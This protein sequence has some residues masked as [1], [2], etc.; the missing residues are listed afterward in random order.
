[1]KNINTIKINLKGGVIAPDN[2]YNIL[3]AASKFRILYVRFGLRQQLLID[4]EIEELK[5]LTAELDMLGI[6]YEVNSEHHPNIVSSY[7]AED[8]FIIKTW[9]TGNIYKQILEDIDHAPQL[10]I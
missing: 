7:P 9:L 10:K 2:F 1:M 8:I 5:D 3:L 6:V 4:V